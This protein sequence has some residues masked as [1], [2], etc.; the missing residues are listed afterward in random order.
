MSIKDRLQEHNVEE[1]AERYLNSY[2]EQMEF[3]ESK[4]QLSKV[5]PI[6]AHDIYALGSQLE[7]FEIYREMCEADGQLSQLGPIPTVAFDVITMTYAT[8]P[9]SLIAS[10]QP[11]DEETGVVY[12]KT[13]R[14]TSTRGNVTAGQVLATPNKLPDVVP[15]GYARETQTQLSAATTAAGTKSYSFTLAQDNLRPGT[16]KVEIAT[17]TDVILSDNG[18]GKLIGYNAQGTINYETGAITL[19]LVNDPGAGKAIN[20]TF[21]TNFEGADDIPTLSSEYS[22]IPVTAEIYALKDSIGMNYSY[23]MR[24]RFGVVAEDEVANHLI[25]ALNSEITNTMIQKYRVKAM[26]NTNWSKTP[27]S[28]VSYAEHKQTF[29]DAIASVEAQILSNTGKGIISV[30]IA[31]KTA[32]ATLS[33]LP[34]FT[35]VTDGNTQGPHIYGT[36]NG[37][38]VIRVPMSSVLPD[39]EILCIYNNQT[40]PFES[41]GV[42]APYMPLMVTQTLPD[43]RNPLRNQRAACVWA[44]TEVMIPGFVSKLTITA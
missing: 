44:A 41:A 12:L 7:N 28:G 11:I 1:K 21:G 26:G 31:G 40:S 25:S 29:Y 3:L 34:G 38:I 32:C 9:I 36:L 4:S 22:T 33:T 17:I 19:L 15:Y 2:R 13:L 42:Y 14:A 35:R 5:R 10:V 18:Q 30:M 39:S 6:G 20:V 16:V 37:V 24:K 23:A 43:G 8:S 27:D